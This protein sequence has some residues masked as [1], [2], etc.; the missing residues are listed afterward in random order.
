MVNFDE[1]IDRKKSYCAKWD[2]QPEEINDDCL[3]PLWVADMDFKVAQPIEKAIE[4]CV[5]HGVYGYAIIPENYDDAIISWMERRHQ[6]KVE[7]D[8]IVLTPGVVTALKIAVQAYSQVDD[9]VL[10][11]KPVYYPFD[12]SIELNK[13]KLIECPLVRKENHYEIDLE[14]LETKIKENDV[15]LIILCNPH[16]PV[17]KVYTK[18]ELYQIGMICKK[19]QV[20]V[21]VDEI[22]QDFVFGNHQHIPFYNVDESFKDFSIICTAPSKTFNLAGLQ[23]SNI[24]IANKNMRKQFIEVKEANGINDPQLFGMVACMSAYNECELWVDEMLEYINDNFIYLDQFLKA[25]MPEIKMMDHEGLYLAWIDFTAMNMT[26]QELEEFMLKKAHLWL[27]EG[28]IFGTGGAG[29]ERFN[30]ALPRSQLAKVCQ[31]L[32]IAYKEKSR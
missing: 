1:I 10:V 31:Q 20:K 12:F 13:R 16:N 2:S 3:I 15:K 26:H 28:Y 4:K 23:T 6:F 5:K 21:I 29:F 9:A 19:Y 18:D 8:W 14:D 30:L 22:H 25:N 7:K 24:I 17:G 11:F 27:D 32:L